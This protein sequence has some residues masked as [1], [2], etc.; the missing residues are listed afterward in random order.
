MTFTRTLYNRLRPGFEAADP[1]AR[2]PRSWVRY[3]IGLTT[4]IIHDLYG[5]PAE[6]AQSW[7]SFA[8]YRYYTVTAVLRKLIWME[9][10]EDWHRLDDA[11][12]S[13]VA[14]HKSGGM[15]GVSYRRIA[16]SD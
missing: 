8:H 11:V 10:L 1:L 13:I 9:L 16:G 7:Y 4:I 12:A 2:L 6:V 3:R 15:L 14:G 5:L